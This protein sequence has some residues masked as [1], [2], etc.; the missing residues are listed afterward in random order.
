MTNEDAHLR[1][2]LIETAARADK[3]NRTIY[4]QFLNMAQQSILLGAARE[5]AVPF[6]LYGGHEACERKMAAFG[7]DIIKEEY[8]IALVLIEP[9]SKKF[10]QELTHR[11]FL[12]SILG[13]GVK[14][15]TIGDL[16][17]S[18]KSAYVFCTDV[19]AAY[20]CENMVSVSRTDV[21]CSYAD[22]IPESFLP[23]PTYRAVNVPSARLDA[24]V[25]GVYNLSRSQAGLLVTQKKVFIDAM[26]TENTS[27]A[28]NENS[29]VSVRGYGRFRYLGVEKVT[30]KDRLRVGVE[31]Y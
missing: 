19:M 10:A 28:V 6:T 7:Y 18:D 16:F 31:V 30:R 20:L 26:L 12:G 24:L 25:A 5:C 29:I 1:A 22:E 17:V 9:L 11:D 15:E 14:R 2:K 4:S 3:Q 8:P 23:Q 21:R 27:K 13:L